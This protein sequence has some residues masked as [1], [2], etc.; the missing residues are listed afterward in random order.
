MVITRNAG[1]IGICSCKVGACRK[2][3][4]TCKRCK[5]ACDGI[6]PVD[7][8]AQ[9]RGRPTKS[10]RKLPK[11]QDASKKHQLR[12]RRNKM[13]CAISEKKNKHNNVSDQPSNE[14]DVSFYTPVND[15]EDIDG[16]V[17]GIGSTFTGKS[18]HSLRKTHQP[19]KSSPDKSKKAKNGILDKGI[20][21]ISLNIDTLDINLLQDTELSPSPSVAN[22]S[23]I[24]KLPDLPQNIITTNSGMQNNI[25]NEDT[26]SYNNEKISMLIDYFKLPEHYKKNLPAFKARAFSDQLLENHH[27]R[28]KRMVTMIVHCIE[29]I[30]NVLCPGPSKNAI[31]KLVR[32]QI[33]YKVEKLGREH[34]PDYKTKYNKLSTSLLLAQKKLKNRSIERRVLRAVL[35]DG[36]LKKDR[37]QLIAKHDVKFATGQ[38]EILARSDYNLL[39]EGKNLEKKKYSYSTKSDKTIKTAVDFI[40]S[41]KFSIPTSYGTHEVYLGNNETITFPNIMR[42]QARTI[43]IDSYL[44]H[45]MNMPH[46]GRKTMYEILRHI[47]STDE[48]TLT[49][50]DYVTSLLVNEPCEVLQS[51]ID[52]CLHPSKQTYAT[53]IVLCARNFLK[54]QFADHVSRSNENEAIC[55]HGIDYGLL[56]EG[57]PRTSHNCCA[58]KFPFYCTSKLKELVTQSPLSDKEMIDDAVK[59]I[60]STTEKFGLYMGHVCRKRSQSSQIKEREQFIQKCCKESE[61]KDIKCLAVMDFKM[62]FESMSARE[63]SVEHFGKRGMGWHGFA[64]MY[65]LWERNP[66][67]NQYCTQKYIIYIDQVLKDG[68]KQDSMTVI[69][70]IESALQVV[71]NEFPFI[72]ELILQSDNASNYQNH[73]VLLGIHLLNI[74]FFNKIFI[75]E[76][77]HS[78]TQDGKTILDAHY[79]T[80]VRHLKKFMKVWR[81]NVVTRI[82]TPKGLAFALTYRGGLLNSIVQLVEIDHIQ[83]ETLRQKFEPITQKLK[84]YFTRVNHI[85]FQQLPDT[86]INNP[87]E[88]LLKGPFSFEA[89]AFS[90]VGRKVKFFI[91]FNDNEVTPDDTALTEIQSVLTGNEKNNKK[92]VTFSTDEIIYDNVNQNITLE[93]ETAALDFTHHPLIT[94]KSKVDGLS[95]MKHTKS[96]QGSMESESDDSDSSYETESDLDGDNDDDD[97]NNMQG[98]VYNDC[99]DVNY[100]EPHKE[101]YGQD[102]FYTNLKIVKQLLVGTPKP[103]LT[104]LDDNNSKV[105]K[106]SRRLIP[107]GKVVRN[108]AIAKA[109]RYA[110]KVISTSNYFKDHKAEDPLYL[111]TKSFSPS[112]DQIFKPGWARRPA[113]GESYGDSYIKYYKHD[114]NKY[115]A[116]GELDSNKKM[117]AG[118]MREMLMRDYPSRFSIPGETE[119]KSWIGA[120]QT[121]KKY[122]KKGT[123]V[124]GRG[125]PSSDY[126]KGDW[127]KIVESVVDMEPSAKPEDLYKS[128]LTLHKDDSMF[129]KDVPRDDSNNIDKKKIKQKINQ[130]KSKLKKNAKMAIL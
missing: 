112:H 63:S 68:A 69:S 127:E 83:L 40:L 52:K 42:A 97:I 12:P 126:I 87:D 115:Y 82:Q 2:C 116:A 122:K 23:N 64:L 30:A 4:S 6:L 125:R 29:K 38:P 5:C 129:P 117:S 85:Y 65:Y 104:L 123:G 58:C 94:R 93:N 32:K 7:A 99:I 43:I 100:S 124:T 77:L 28:S 96:A 102:L 101:Y 70:L 75:S 67:T 17:T 74:K 86:S 71:Y 89:S 10:Q 34:E 1:N 49:A 105:K 119:I 35:Y 11:K 33:K 22:L 45:T 66:T 81:P 88:E 9:N 110:S 21:D 92:Q 25:F 54:H 55:Y 60:D 37:M 44:R 79:G 61:G 118:K 14:D 95:K 16:F 18:L 62:K 91:N 15:S 84:E 103:H 27:S 80:C 57:L 46:L 26:L 56:K 53:S 114:L 19:N 121:K 76:Y 128:F 47:T 50:I 78:E 3:G 130:Y 106:K 41:E 24:P 72:N 51:I 108:D 90:G 36:S 98:L 13:I 20:M 107:D 113:H 59:V 111:E 8:L 48:V 39:I 120:Q 31:L 109:I 73:N